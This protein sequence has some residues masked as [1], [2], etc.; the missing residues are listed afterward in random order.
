MMKKKFEVFELDDDI[1]GVV[2]R[3]ANMW[4]IEPQQAMARLIAIGSSLLDTH[5]DDELEMI[6]RRVAKRI[7]KLVK[8]LGGK[9][10]EF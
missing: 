9:S 2:Y 7:D 5:T 6:R 4:D 8:E 3:F 10:V 1:K